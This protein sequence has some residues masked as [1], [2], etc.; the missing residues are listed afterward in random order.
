MKTIATVFRKELIDT[1]RDRRT[2]IFMIVIPVLL[3]PVLF[4]IM[5]SVQES[6][7]K[8]AQNKTL[9]VDI[10]DHGNAARLVD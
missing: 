4:K 9:A 5:F 1:I 3:F 10:Y 2:I 8:K 6:H 7:T